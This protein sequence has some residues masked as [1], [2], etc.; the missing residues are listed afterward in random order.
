MV[1]S[2][3]TALGIAALKSLFLEVFQRKGNSAI[4]RID[5]NVIF[6]NVDREILGYVN[7]YIYR[8]ARIKVLNMRDSVHLEDIYTDSEL[9]LSKQD[10]HGFNSIEELQEKYQ[11]IGDMLSINRQDQ[12]RASAIEFIKSNSRTVVLGGPGA[13][14]T[15]LLK[16]AGIEALKYE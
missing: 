1:S 3:L 10:P 9:L 7:G 5:V 16:K 4:D 13:G 2:G 11:L 15:T 12:E 8:H 6:R 14:K